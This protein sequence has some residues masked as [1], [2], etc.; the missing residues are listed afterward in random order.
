[1]PTVRTSSVTSVITPISASSVPSIHPSGNECKEI[2][3]EIPGTTYGEKFPSKITMKVPDN[4]TLTLCNVKLLERTPGNSN[5]VNFM[6][7]LLS[8]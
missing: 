6:V 2:L 7:E 3:D 8:G 5:G 4:K 1:M